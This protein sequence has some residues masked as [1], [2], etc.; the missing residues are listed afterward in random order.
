MSENFAMSF[1]PLPF[2][3]DDDSNVRWPQ[4]PMNNEL[5]DQ[6]P[7]LKMPRILSESSHF[8]LSHQPIM[9][10]RNMQNP[11]NHVTNNKGRTRHI[12]YKT[13]LCDKFRMGRCRNGESCNYAHG[14]EDLRQ[15]PA[16]WQ[17]L[18]VEQKLIDKMTLCKK[19]YNGEEC[20]Y[21][22]RCCYIHEDPS[23]FRD[24]A[25]RCRESSVISNNNAEN[26]K[27]V[28]NGCD[29]FR[30][31]GNSLWNTKL[32]TKWETTGQC[33]FGDKCHFAHGYAGMCF[34]FIAIQQRHFQLQLQL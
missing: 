22:E 23:K 30:T 1:S 7:P 24:D 26:H 28:N 9:N 27:S 33:P 31:N 12:F 2:V 13:R 4:F 16:N 6:L 8:D 21:G 17:E 14:N 10:P 29:G 15:P 3:V 25:G 32:C 20:P 11:Q 34:K 5:L 19:Y 18:V